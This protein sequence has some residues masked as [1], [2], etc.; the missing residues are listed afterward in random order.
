MISENL[1]PEENVSKLL[2]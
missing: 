1:F 2:Q